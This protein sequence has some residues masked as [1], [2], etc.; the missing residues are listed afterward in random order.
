ME[1]LDV[2]VGR[3]NVNVFFNIFSCSIFQM[4]VDNDEH[5]KN[6]RINISH[7]WST[8]L[9]KLCI[10]ATIFGII[11]WFKRL[12]IRRS[13]N[14]NKKKEILIK[15]K[16][17]KRRNA[18]KNGTI[19]NFSF[20]VRQSYDTFIEHT[21]RRWWIITYVKS[22]IEKISDSRTNARWFYY[23]ISSTGNWLNCYLVCRMQF[24]SIFFCTL[25]IN[26]DSI[27]L[28]SI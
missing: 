13:T 11:E 5:N 6:H 7:D 17:T 14:Y 27:R 22:W 9:I 15:N 21:I 18:I 26:G 1:A 20:N 16:K 10:R 8:I 12:K 3:L 28:K 23:V 24:F 2:F 25:P 4:N 19:T